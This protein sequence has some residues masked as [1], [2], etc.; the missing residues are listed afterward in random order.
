MTPLRL[1]Q[2]TANYEVGK[3]G[4]LY[5][6]QTIPSRNSLFIYFINNNIAKFLNSN[7]N[8][9][10]PGHFVEWLYTLAPVYAFEFDAERYDIGDIETYRKVNELYERRGV[11]SGG[12]ME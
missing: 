9:D 4:I 3:I 1:F 5:I 10:A 6:F 12:V 7:Q 11:R 8:H 2:Q